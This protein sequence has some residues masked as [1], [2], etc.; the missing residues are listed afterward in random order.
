MIKTGTLN[1]ND[2]LVKTFDMLREMDALELETI[3]SYINELI[4]GNDNFYRPLSEEELIKRID[5]SIAE[6]DAGLVYD[7]EEAAKEIMSELGL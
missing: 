3:R 6:A 5:E 1:H 2:K 4:S 7:A